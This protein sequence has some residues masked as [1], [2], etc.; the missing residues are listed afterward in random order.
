MWD[1]TELVENWFPI[2]N[3]HWKLAE[4]RA[5]AYYANFI[6]IPCLMVGVPN[7]IG[8]DVLVD[9]WDRPLRKWQYWDEDGELSQHDDWYQPWFDRIY[10]F[11]YTTVMDKPIK[12]WRD[13][14]VQNKYS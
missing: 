14:P 13:N 9:P 6:T 7:G 11:R 1:A 2:M 4:G 5:T 3:V 10:D 8:F 12:L